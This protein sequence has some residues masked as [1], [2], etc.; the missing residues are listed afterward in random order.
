MSFIVLQSSGPKLL[1]KDRHK[2]DHS[3]DQ[4]TNCDLRD[5][6]FHICYLYRQYVL[7][8]S[9]LHSII[10]N[11]FIKLLTFPDIF[12]KQQCQCW[13]SKITILKPTRRSRRHQLNLCL[14]LMR[15]VYS[16]SHGNVGKL[17]CSYVNPLSSTLSTVFK[18]LSPISEKHQSDYFD[19]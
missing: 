2:R 1:T 17:R 10:P 16:R 4:S 8:K 18:Y 12:Y 6:R 11:P 7:P 19:M 5:Q 13:W 15:S 3:E 14:T 9:V